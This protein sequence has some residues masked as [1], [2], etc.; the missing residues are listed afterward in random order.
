MIARAGD[1]N[2]TQSEVFAAVSEAHM[3]EPTADQRA[4]PSGHTYQVRDLWDS[5]ASG[6]S[7]KYQ[8]GRLAGRLTQFSGELQARIATGQVLDLG[9]GSGELALHL[10]SLGYGVTGCDI[11]QQMLERAMGADTENAVQ[12]IGLK[13]EWT[14]LPLAPASLDAVVAASVLEY[15][16]DPVVV[17]RECA[18]VLRP[19][20]VLLCTVPDLTH[21]ARWGESLLR[22]PAG[23]APIRAMSGRV[24]PRLG[25]HLTYL[26]LSRQRRST[27]WWHANGRRAGLEPSPRAKGGA[28]RSRLQLLAFT[29]PAEA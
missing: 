3:P 19:D 17:L 1:V 29:R 26:C 7:D 11:A 14:T 9:C 24:W 10:A 22:L 15:V 8:N 18:R 23:V 6:W 16:L 12:W 13:P 2:L 21:P 27:R 20:G 25:S 4:L 28:T 5:R